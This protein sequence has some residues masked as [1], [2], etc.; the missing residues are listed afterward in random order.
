V[1][2]G[3]G[4]AGEGDGQSGTDWTPR[5]VDLIVADYFDMLQLEL[6]GQPFVKAHRNEALR[7]IVARSDGDGA[8]Y[9]IRSFTPAGAERLVEVK[10]TTGDRTTPLNPT[11]YRASF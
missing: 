2:K 4:N 9:D 3:L 11:A 10:T 6:A 8:G 1:I 7:Q 5:E